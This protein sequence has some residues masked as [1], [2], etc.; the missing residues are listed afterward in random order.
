MI[1]ELWERF[2]KKPEPVKEV[3]Q[4]VPVNSVEVDEPVASITFNIE[5]DGMIWIMGNWDGE[6]MTGHL[7]GEMLYRLNSGQMAELIQES[8]VGHFLID[9]LLL[10]L[11]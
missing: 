7:L 5:E 6:H 11:F 9:L 10:I 2:S 1:K 8:L 4:P 3:E